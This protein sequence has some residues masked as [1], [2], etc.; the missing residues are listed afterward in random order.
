[1]S[2]TVEL[3]P[4]ATGLVP[5][6]TVV[7]AGTPDADKVTGVAKPFKE[8][9]FIEVAALVPPQVATVT[10]LLNANSADGEFCMVKL[11]FEIS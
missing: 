11:A 7:P 9:V 3:L 6:V 5:K 1:M 10:G 8:A 4:G 2:V